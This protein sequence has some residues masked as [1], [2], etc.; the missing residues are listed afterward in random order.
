M[1]NYPGASPEVVENDVSTPIENAVQGVP[2]LESTSATSTTNA[3]IV[4]ATFTYGTNLATA[5]QKMQQ[6][7]NRISQG[8]PKDVA[9][10]VLSVSIDDFPVIQIAVTGFE[11]SE[12]AQTD[13]ES[14]VIPEL[15]DVQGVNAADIVGGVGQRITITPD[16][17]KLA[18]A[19]QGT[20]A[21]SQALQ[22]NGVLLPGG[23]ITEGG[24]TLTVQSGSKIASAEELAA[25]PL[26]GTDLTVGDVAKVAQTTDPVTSIS[27]VDG[28][29][30]L[31]IAVTKLPSA[32][33]VEVSQGV[34]AALDELSDTFPDAEFTVVFDQAPFIE[35][36]IETLAT[37]GML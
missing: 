30:A 37:E 8:L 7:I 5:E 22:Q 27:R 23:E 10:Q 12:S 19:R 17:V 31:S 35:Q 15:E 24:Q 36:S 20:Q 28:E 1:T 33:T 32:N 4:Q 16:A 14:T 34:L 13:L 6:A 26:T 21:I 11:D 3:S 29:D 9:P 18:A 25:L 2:G